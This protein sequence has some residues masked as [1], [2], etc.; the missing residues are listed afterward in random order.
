MSWKG[1]GC[2]G[3]AGASYCQTYLQITTVLQPLTLDDF[4]GRILL[5]FVEKDSSAILHLSYHAVDCEGRCCLYGKK[6][7]L[8]SFTTC[9][10]LQ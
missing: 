3:W 4:L 1:L 8:Q 2:A 7:E 9:T 5:V 10:N 6:S